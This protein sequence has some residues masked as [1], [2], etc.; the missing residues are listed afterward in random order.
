MKIIW[1][2]KAKKDLINIADFIARDK[3]S[4]ALKWLQLVKS[5]VSRLSKFP[6]SGRMVPEIKRQDIR[7]M[8][9]GNYRVIYKVGTT[10]SILT[11]FH[12]A[13]QLTNL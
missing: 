7:E 12:G 4:A 9:I 3:Q 11:V 6:R 10:I 5:K 1:S 8:I 2:P 13:K